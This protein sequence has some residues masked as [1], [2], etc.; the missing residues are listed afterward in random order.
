LYA[1]PTTHRLLVDIGSVNMVPPTVDNTSSGPYTASFN[2]GYSSSSIGDLVYLDSS[3][4]WQKADANTPATTYSGILAVA[5]EVKS[6]GEAL[7]VALNGSMIYASG[8][9]SAL[10]IG[11]PIYMSETAGG[12]TQTAPT[13]TDSA[14]RIMGYAIHA[15][16]IWFVPDNSYVVHT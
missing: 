14:T 10:T 7:T 12:W 15:N 16:K 8:V 1:D 4:T 13:T 6:T 9:F 5:L 2:C 3:G 11:S